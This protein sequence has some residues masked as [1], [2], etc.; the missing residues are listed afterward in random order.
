M[1]IQ[2]KN[3]LTVL[4]S[5]VALSAAATAAFAANPSYQPEGGP[6]DTSP[7]NYYGA[8]ERL[9][10]LGAVPAGKST[11]QPEGGPTDV[12]AARHEDHETHR[13]HDK[14]D[15]ARDKV[16]GKMGREDDDSERRANSP[17]Y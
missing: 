7:P 17:K 5:V 16:R 10:P 2:I 3:R 4:A 9:V 11:Y 15:R 13:M 1:S 14:V 6:T 12:D 8:P